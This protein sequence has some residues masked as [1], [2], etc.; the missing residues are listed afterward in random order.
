MDTLNT[1]G[2]PDQPQPTKKCWT[3]IKHIK[4]DN[5]GVS[6]LKEEARRQADAEKAEILNWQFQSVFIR[7]IKEQF[8]EEEFATW[9]PM[10]RLDPNQS[11][12]EDIR[13]SVS[14]V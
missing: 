3:F 10:P 11:L 12:S 1:E 5:K 13:I 14:G 9:C 7:S 6:L 4:S 2:T 8:V